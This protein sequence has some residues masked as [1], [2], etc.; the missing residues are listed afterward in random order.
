MVSPPHDEREQ[1]LRAVMQSLE[2]SKVETIA[3]W[4]RSSHGVRRS[5][6][7]PVGIRGR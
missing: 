2:H 1:A 6:G 7:V 5:E 3:V 4:Q